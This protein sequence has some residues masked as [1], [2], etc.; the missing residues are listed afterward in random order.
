[1]R[2]F[3]SMKQFPVFVTLAAPAV[4][5]LRLVRSIVVVSLSDAKAKPQT[6]ARFGEKRCFGRAV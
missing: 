1:M 4:A 2:T 6:E 5:Q 3:D